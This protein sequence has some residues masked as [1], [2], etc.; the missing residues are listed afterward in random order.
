MGVAI[1]V[2][3][4]VTIGVA[5]WRS[6]GRSCRR[7]YGINCHSTALCYS[8]KEFS[9]CSLSWMG[10]WSLIFSEI[11]FLNLSRNASFLSSDLLLM[12]A[13]RESNNLSKRS[14]LAEAPNRRF[15]WTRLKKRTN[16]GR[17]NVL[18]PKTNQRTGVVGC[19]NSQPHF[20]GFSLRDWEWPWE[21]GFEMTMISLDRELS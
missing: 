20:Q 12:R 5:V 11:V 17:F 8:C 3:V 9:L 15:S 7:G 2:A 13:R 6:Y 19:E 4:G 10:A 18:F 1:G 21:R 14:R 16:D